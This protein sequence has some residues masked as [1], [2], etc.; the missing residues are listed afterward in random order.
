MLSNTILLPYW[1]LSSFY[2]FNCAVLGAILPFWGL[3]LE[4]LDF[5]SQQIG[6]FVAIIL[7]SNI[8]APNFWGWLTDRMNNRLAVIQWGTMFSLLSFLMVLFTTNYTLLALIVFVSCFCWQG[9]NSQF[10]VIT[11][12]FCSMESGSRYGKIR[13]WGSVGFIASVLILGWLFELISLFN[14]PILIS[15]L[16]F[17][18]WLSTMFLPK[19]DVS[20]QAVVSDDES[21]DGF[22]KILLK[23]AILALFFATFLLKFSH[24]TYYTFFSIYVVEFGFSSIELGWLWSVAVI[25]EIGM[26]FVVHHFIAKFGIR[27]VFIFS[28]LAAV[29]RWALIS[30]ASDVLFVI[31][32]SQLLH[33]LTFSSLHT[34]VLMYIK[35]NFGEKYQGQAVAFYC[36]FCVAA[37]GA[38]GASVSGYFWD[39]SQQGTFM[40]SSAVAFVATLIAWIY[41]KQL[42]YKRVASNN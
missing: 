38:L 36:S 35:N 18:M 17:C 12:R 10:E 7:A 11:L 21:I 20:N 42:D 16:L 13:L 28:L 4:K 30:V 6:Y 34:V 5:S 3:Y 39:W 33:A 31:I 15:I 26:F 41:V 8:I 24:G 29:L 40:M 2:F 23:P 22:W 25:A 27:F 19:G 32:F 9:L 14:L 37:G 1:R